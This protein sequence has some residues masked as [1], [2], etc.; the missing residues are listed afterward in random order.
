MRRHPHHFVRYTIGLLLIHIPRLANRKFLLE[1]QLF[2]AAR[3]RAAASA[4]VG[5]SLEQVMARRRRPLNDPE[6]PAHGALCGS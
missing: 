1:R 3:T 2:L 4:L 6:R 5:F